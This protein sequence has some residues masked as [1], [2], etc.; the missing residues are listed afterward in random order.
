MGKPQ[1]YTPEIRFV[2]FDSEIVDFGSNVLN[3]INMIREMY[4]FNTKT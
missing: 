2:R 1:P 3:M 4:Q